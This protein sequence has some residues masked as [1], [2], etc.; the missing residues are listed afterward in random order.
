MA[1]FAVDTSFLNQPAPKQQTLGDLVNM[2][3]G[4]QNYQ[5][6]QQLN[7]VQLENAQNV[8][9]QNKLALEKAQ[10]LNPMDIETAKLALE[11]RRALQNP[12]IESGKAKSEREVYETKQK[13]AT[14]LNDAM[15]A[16]LQSQSLE[17]RDLPSF[18]KHV[19]EQRERLIDQGMPVHVAETQF[20]KLIDAAQ[21]KGLDF[22]EQTLQNTQK[23][24]LGASERQGLIT[25]Q[26]T[27]INGVKY[28]VNPTTQKLTPVGGGQTAPSAPQ[29]SQAPQMPQGQSPR[30]V[31]E[32]PQMTVPPG[33]QIPQ[34]NQQQK[35]AYENGQTLK[36]ASAGIAKNSQDA[37]QTIRK[38]EQFADK[39]SGSAP[40]QA[41]RT[42]GKYLFGDANY[43]ELLKNIARMQMDNATAMGTSTD[44]AR[45]TAEIASGSADI[46]EKALRDI[47]A[48][49]KA[50]ATGA[51]KFESGLKSYIGKRGDYNG[52]INANKFKEAW[53]ANYDP[54]LLM[55]QNINESN[56]PKEE[57][58]KMLKE[59][60]SNLTKEEA[61]TLR[62]KQENLMRLEKGEY[63]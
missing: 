58:Q 1:T 21:T 63:Q 43:D 57:K 20:N 13:Y 15:T 32:D 25:P 6:A 46:T 49:A 16:M 12:E 14:H 31:Q 41:L 56:L 59:I 17:K 52:N 33:V 35:A 7:P 8:L 60:N 30:L 54:R 23:S 42:S 55:V 45:Q 4:I 18:I 48:R 9:Q 62:K 38:V 11:Q 40:G 19:R 39:A 44:S 5:Q 61:M 26:V 27:E 3:S 10:T 47:I 51:I 24:Q 34:L 2:A 29:M 50:D 22:V 28:F 53:I 36:N 37:L